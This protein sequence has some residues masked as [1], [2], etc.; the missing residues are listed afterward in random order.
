MVCGR[1]ERR[2]GPG[3]PGTAHPLPRSGSEPSGVLTPR[4]LAPP[5]GLP[6]RRNRVSCKYNGL[7][8]FLVSRAGFSKH[9]KIV[10]KYSQIFLDKKGCETQY[11]FGCFNLSYKKLSNKSQHFR[12]V[13]WNFVNFYSKLPRKTRGDFEWCNG[14][15]FLTKTDAK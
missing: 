13:W 8:C 11:N 7:K 6:G 3:I 4:W 15:Y 2:G 1:S 10:Q 14:R 9:W 12:E 5:D